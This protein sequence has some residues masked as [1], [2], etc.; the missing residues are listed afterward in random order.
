MFNIE[1]NWGRAVIIEMSE[2]LLA[3]DSPPLDCL[4][5]GMFTHTGTDISFTGGHQRTLF[6]YTITAY[7][8]RLCNKYKIKSLGCKIID[9]PLKGTNVYEHKLET[10]DKKQF[11][12]YQYGPCPT[13]P[14]DHLTLSILERNTTKGCKHCNYKGFIDDDIECTTC[15][16]GAVRKLIIDNPECKTFRSYGWD[17]FKDVI[18]KSDLEILE[19]FRDHY[20]RFFTDDFLYKQEMCPLMKEYVDSKRFGE[21]FEADLERDLLMLYR[22]EEEDEDDHEN[23]EGEDPTQDD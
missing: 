2:I 22:D 14:F 16:N 13:S 23:D 3:K 9:V 11:Y 7:V 17:I 1:S 19:K 4:L 12:C 6:E 15:R 5:A 20:I 18:S 21:Y 8:N 10:L